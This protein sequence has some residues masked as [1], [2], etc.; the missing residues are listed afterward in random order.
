M[1]YKR[2]AMNYKIF[3][4]VLAVAMVIFTGCHKDVFDSEALGRD[5]FI[6]NIFSVPHF[7]Q[8]NRLLVL[9]FH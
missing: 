9:F 5:Y 3:I 6:E 1:Y 7:R 2:T 8:P 4:Y